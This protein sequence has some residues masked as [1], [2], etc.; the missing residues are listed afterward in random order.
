MSYSMRARSCVRRQPARQGPDRRRGREGST[1][2]DRSTPTAGRLL[3]PKDPRPFREGVDLDPKFEAGAEQRR[4]AKG[5]DSLTRPAPFPIAAPFLETRTVFRAR[6]AWGLAADD[7]LAIAPPRH[8][9]HH[10][11]KRTSST[12]MYAQVDAWPMTTAWAASRTS[13]SRAD[14]PKQTGRSWSGSWGSCNVVWRHG[15]KLGTPSRSS[16]KTSSGV[17]MGPER[18]R[19]GARNA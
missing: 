1:T 11:H 6:L 13:S 3:P 19:I 18:G 14:L 7:G 4:S 10:A 15:L 2:A 16:E 5:P 12:A 9:R 8:V 17:S